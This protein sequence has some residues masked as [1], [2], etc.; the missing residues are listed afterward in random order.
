M[1]SSAPTARRPGDRAFHVR[2]ANN[3]PP[4]EDPGVPTPGG[5]LPGAGV[6]F[7]EGSISTVPPDCRTVAT[8][9]QKFRWAADGE[10]DRF[11][12]LLDEN[13][14]F[15]HLTGP[16]QLQAGMGGTAARRRLRLPPDEIRRLRP[17]ARSTASPTCSTTTSPSCT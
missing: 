10:I 9:P 12:D 11:A 15:V 3:D 14:A 8:T 4:R 13:L 16:D 17:T 6:I 1:A 5:L 7:T 2:V